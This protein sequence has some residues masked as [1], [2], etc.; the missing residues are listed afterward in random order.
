MNDYAML[1]EEVIAPAAAVA[2]PVIAEVQTNRELLAF[3]NHV[4]IYPNSASL[5]IAGLLFIVP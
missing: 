3:E 2:R 1:G 4:S 5:F